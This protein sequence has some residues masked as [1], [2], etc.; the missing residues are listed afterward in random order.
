MKELLGN[1]LLQPFARQLSSPFLWRFNRHGVARGMAVGLFA[2]FAFPIAQ[3]PVAVLLAML[4]R[5]NLPVA[6]VAT[7]TTN[8]F[9]VP[10]IYYLAFRVGAHF[11]RGE[12]V[13]PELTPDNGWLE[14]T[15]SWLA[16]FAGPTMLGLFIFGCLSAVIGFF[17]VHVGWR[18]WISQRWR[19]RR[20]PSKEGQRAPGIVQP[21]L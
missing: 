5:G 18:L 13:S 20:Y 15:F 19:R 17:C 4:V 8:P 7:F 9:T 11:W 10:L 12:R 16:A 6:S 3:L 21:K 1:R 2:A 14:Q